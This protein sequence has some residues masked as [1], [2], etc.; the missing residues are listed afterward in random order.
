MRQRAYIQEWLYQVPE[1]WELP[2]L[3]LMAQVESGH[4]PSRSHPEY[5]VTEECNIPWFSLADIW[6]LRDGRQ[7]YLGD[8]KE[9][10]SPLGIANSGARILPAG[11]V[12][13]SRTASVG[14]SGIMPTPMATTQ[15]FVNFVCG[16]R[17]HNR[18]LMWVLR[19]MKPEFERLRQGSTHKTIYMPDALQF[20]TPMPPLSTQ[21]AISDFLDRKTAAIDALIEKKQKLLDLLA[22]KRA[23][24]INQTVTRGLDPDVPMKDSGIPWIGEIPAHWGVVLL[25]L[26]ARL[27]SGH[28]PSRSRPEYWVPNECTVPWFTLADVWQLRSGKQLYLGKTKECISE[29]GMANSS[30]RLLPT[31]TV[32]L[33]RTASV[34]FTGVMPIPMATTQDFANWVCG[35]LL[36]PEFLCTTF[37]G[38]G[39]EFNRIKM[40]STHQTIYM[41]DIRQIGIPLPPIE[42]QRSIAVEALR[43]TEGMDAAANK[44]GSQID[45]LQEY[46]QALITA[47]VTGQLDITEEAAA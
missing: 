36:H 22:E 5:W 45:R 42:E 15:D 37:R 43:Q 34:G 16:P 19:G 38:M 33:S 12:V 27:E 47:A 7:I 40:G 9:K 39:S 6:Q 4:T 20:R 8:T 21:K 23:A 18:Y 44:V 46:R 10:V 30:A 11:T 14:F 25:R 32:V 3:K 24:L 28:T 17:L 26:M 13:L 29:T 41:P 31:G 35:P 1:D 2:L